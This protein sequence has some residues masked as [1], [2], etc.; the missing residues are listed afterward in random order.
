MSLIFLSTLIEVSVSKEL[1]YRL[2]GGTYARWPVASSCG[3]TDHLLC[4]TVYA[5]CRVIRGQQVCYVKPQF[6]KVRV[7]LV[8]FA[9]F[10]CRSGTA[11]AFRFVCM[12]RAGAVVSSNEDVLFCVDVCYVKAR[13]FIILFLGVCSFVGF[14]GYP[15][16]SGLPSFYRVIVM[17]GV[18]YRVQFN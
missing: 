9:A 7:V 1:I 16:F 10:P 3:S 18:G 8:L 12:L 15:H 11:T 17:V 14:A 5:C 4:T 2:V 6:I 13:C